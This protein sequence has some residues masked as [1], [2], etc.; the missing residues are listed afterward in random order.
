MCLKL[1]PGYEEG[2]LGYGV[3]LFG[4]GFAKE[5]IAIMDEFLEKNGFLPSHLLSPLLCSLNALICPFRSWMAAQ[6]FPTAEYIFPHTDVPRPLVRGRIQEVLRIG[7]VEQATGS[8]LLV[9][10]RLDRGTGFC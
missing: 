4:Y 9:W 8:Q 5:A 10:R 2:M 1:D 7:M 3:H 6:S